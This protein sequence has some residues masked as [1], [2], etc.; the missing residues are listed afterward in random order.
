MP[1]GGLEPPRIAPYAP[2]TH[3]STIPPLR[4]S[5]IKFLFFY[6]YTSVAEATSRVALSKNDTQSFFCGRVPLRHIT[7]KYHIPV[8]EYQ[9]STHILLHIYYTPIQIK[10][11]IILPTFLD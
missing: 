3:V 4:H 2:E 5:T 7:I 6:Y 8:T 1:E 9:I 10:R 11:K